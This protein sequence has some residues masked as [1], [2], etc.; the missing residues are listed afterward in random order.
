MRT[1]ILS[2]GASKEL[3]SLVPAIRDH[4]LET[5]YDF[6]VAPASREFDIKRL[7]GKMSLRLRV[8]DWRVIF[9][10]SETHIEVFTIAHRSKVYR[11]MN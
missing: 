1:V 4:V 7:K 8:G 11:R 2:R 6:A 3:D 10:V 9:D 5:L